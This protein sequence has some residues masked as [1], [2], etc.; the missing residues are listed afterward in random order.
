MVAFK[1]NTEAMGL[2]ASYTVASI[3]TTVFVMIL[4]LAY[5]SQRDLLLEWTRESFSELW[6]LI[7]LFLKTV[8]YQF[9]MRLFVEVGTI[10]ISLLGPDDLGA[11][12]ILLRYG[13]IVLVTGMGFWIASVALMGRAAG[14]G[15]REKFVSIFRANFSIFIAIA[16][17]MFF[18]LCVLRYQLAYASTS[19]PKVQNILVGLTPFEAMYL[20]VMLLFIGS[21]SLL[22]SLGKVNVPTITTIVCEFIVGMPLAMVLTFGTSLRL[23]GFY[24]GLTVSYIL[25]LCII[26]TYYICF[27]NDILA[28]IDGS[29]NETASTSESSPFLQKAESVQNV[30]A[31]PSAAP[32]SAVN[33]YGTA[34]P[35]SASDK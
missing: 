15:K 6:E 23:Y 22:L 9:S 2:A 17:I 27:W 35:S 20:A 10:F 32:N 34:D 25:K 4:M 14:R 29:T 3:L 28:P 7:W 33:T 18:L 5:R 21:H 31:P 13:I 12:F 11:Q 19:L 1:L 8:A 16:I 24:I 26:W 30:E